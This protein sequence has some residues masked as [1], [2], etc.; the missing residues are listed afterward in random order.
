MQ[1]RGYR[2]QVQLRIRVLEADLERLNRL[3]A[4][5]RDLYL[6]LFRWVLGIISIF[7]VAVTC[8]IIGFA[9]S[10]PGLLT[11]SVVLDYRLD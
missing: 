8:G 7:V 4:S 2:A 9:N 6:Y 10:Q 11:T 1:E 5:D 3:K